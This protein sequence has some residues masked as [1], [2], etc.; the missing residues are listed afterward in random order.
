M[1]N[2]AS[3]VGSK[4]RALREA[5][6]ITP[7]E[8][9]TKL[10]V[11][12][13]AVNRYETGARKA[14]QDTL[15]DLAKIFNVSI[16]D[17]FPNTTS[18]GNSQDLIDIYEQLLPERQ[19]RVYNYAT[20]QLSKQK[21]AYSSTVGENKR[22]VYIY[23]AVS[24][25]TGEYIPQ[26]ED[27]PEKAIVEGVVPDHDFA[28]RVNGDSM[29]P[30]FTNQQIIYV[31]KTDKSD[32]RNNQ[33][34]IAELNGEFFVKKLHMND[35]GNIKLISLNKKYSDIVIHDYDDF[36]IRGVVII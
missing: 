25:G 10:G 3:Y 15:F 35:D 14:N 8:L 13:V 31:N 12:R 16:N 32:V 29:E 5:R 11:S 6:N 24:A 23:G 21:N 9:A 1:E 18:I 17:F 19:K 20:T 36:I 34:I 22:I 4:I 30:I 28:V 26:D 7:E 2:L 27:K 33:F